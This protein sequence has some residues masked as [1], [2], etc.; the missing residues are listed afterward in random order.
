MLLDVVQ[1]R[2]RR[3]NRDDPNGY[4]RFA[5]LVTKPG[6]ICRLD[7][8]LLDTTALAALF[9]PESHDMAFNGGS[10]GAGQQ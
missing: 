1:L 10:D 5:A 2:L 7:I 8:D 9:D 4:L 6:E 3:P